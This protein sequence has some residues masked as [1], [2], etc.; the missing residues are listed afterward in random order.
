M[1]RFYHKGLEKIRNKMFNMLKN[2]LSF[3]LIVFI[4]GACHGNSNDCVSQFRQA[5]LSAHNEFRSRHGSG[6]L[7]ETSELD[8][9]AQSYAQ[10]LAANNRFSHSRAKNLGENLYMM[11]GGSLN[12][13]RKSITLCRVFI[14]FLNL[15]IKNRIWQKLRNIMVQR[16]L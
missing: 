1:K 15:L 12:C 5:T 6:P 9:G 4:F 8:E 13:A 14:Q 2:F 10:Y 16:S 11:S 3:V 7:Q